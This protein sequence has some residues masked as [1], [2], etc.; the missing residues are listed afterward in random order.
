MIQSIALGLLAGLFIANG[1][2]HFVK[3]ITHDR[4]PTVFGSGPVVNLVAGW[5]GIVIGT[6]LLVA[7]DL[8]A[9]PVAGGAAVAVGVLLMG[10]FHAAAGAFGKADRVS[11][12]RSANQGDT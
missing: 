4:Y 5:S 7:A 6:L 10:L 8:P 9:E 11:V 2:P 3:G 1:I 12:A